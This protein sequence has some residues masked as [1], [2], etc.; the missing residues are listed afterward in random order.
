MKL[1]DSPNILYPHPGAVFLSNPA[2]KTPNLVF[3]RRPR[4][5]PLARNSIDVCRPFLLLSHVR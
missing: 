4:A 2:R 3:P 5:L 1:T